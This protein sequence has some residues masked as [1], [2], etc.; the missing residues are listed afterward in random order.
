MAA[1]GSIDFDLTRD[2]IIQEALEEIGVLAI[3]ETPSAAQ[4]TTCG[5]S[6]NLMLKNWQA[7]GA[8]LFAVQKTYL[9]LN[10]DVN[11]YLIG[12]TASYST[13][14][15]KTTTTAASSSGT[16]TIDIAADAGISGTSEMIIE[17]DSGDVQHVGATSIATLTVTL[18][19]NLSDD[20][21]SGATVYWYDTSANRP[22]K[23]LSGVLRDK[24]DIDIPI[25]TLTLDEY[26]TLSDKTSTGPAVQAYFNPEVDLMRARLWPTPDDGTDYLVL[27]VQKT[28]DDY[29]A[30]ADDSTYPQEWL[31]PIAL[32]LAVRVHRKFGIPSSEIRDTK[33]R[34]KEAYDLAFGY[35]REGDFTIQ[36]DPEGRRTS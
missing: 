18:D 23:V 29:D 30:A 28:L 13:D 14:I 34:A 10:K 4:L 8:N 35:D 5:R 32:S 1:S 33:M 15:N 36:P 16:N 9:F 22:M 3:G 31:E 11:E 6:L 19:A 24:N 17:L 21:N 20:V 25:D 7:G 2:D 27:W 26:A 12:S